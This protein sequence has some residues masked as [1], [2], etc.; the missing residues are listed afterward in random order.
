MSAKR[1]STCYFF[2][3]QCCN[4]NPPVPMLAP[5]RSIQGDGLQIIGARP[6][7]QAHDYCGSWQPEINIATDGIRG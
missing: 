1:C 7:V 5:V 3:N 6:P 4:L 2:Q